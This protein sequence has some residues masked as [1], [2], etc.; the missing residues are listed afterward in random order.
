MVSTFYCIVWHYFGHYV[1]PICVLFIG[2]FLKGCLYGT[3]YIGQAM[4][5]LTDIIFS[6]HLYEKI[7]VISRFGWQ[8]IWALFFCKHQHMKNDELH[9]ELL[10]KGLVLTTGDYH[11]HAVWNL[12]IIQEEQ[13]IDNI[14]LLLAKQ[15]PLIYWQYQE[16]L[17]PH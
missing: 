1:V 15:D 6:M 4:Y 12:L 16:V 5:W 13:K 8:F 17:A 2:L 10:M 11:M 7:K 14:N 9:E 3:R